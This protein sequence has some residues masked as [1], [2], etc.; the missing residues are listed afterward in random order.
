MKVQAMTSID[1]ELK[2]RAKE[3]GLNLS[4]LLEEKIKEELGQTITA[5]EKRCWLCGSKDNL[6]WTLPYEV[7]MCNKCQKGEINKISICSAKR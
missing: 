1:E 5:E 7:W 3:E 4:Q 2:I 6:I